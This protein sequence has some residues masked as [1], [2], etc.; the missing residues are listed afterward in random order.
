MQALD[1]IDYSNNWLTLVFLFALLL[2][3][4]L[5]TSN[6]Q[7]LFGYSS[8]FFMK[9]FI[10]KKTEER[11]SLLNTFNIVLL[12]FSVIVYAIFISLITAFFLDITASFTVFISVLGFVFIYLVLFLVLDVGLAKLF[13]VQN[14]TSYLFSTKIAY[15]YNT[16][17]ILFPVLII[18]YYSS[19][20][21]SV[22]LF[23]FMMLFL[24]SLLLLFVNNKNLIL[25]KLF[26]FI[27]YLC[28]LEI[29]PLLIIYKMMG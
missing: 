24:L 12:C 14:E 16:S 2:L 1:R 5:K 13:E 22:L 4:V 27:L 10:G 9:G 28:A 3:V 19:L 11:E 18:I 6:Q 17:L 21:I 23:V 29:A 8:A 25:N 7:K 15:L 20:S 26:Y